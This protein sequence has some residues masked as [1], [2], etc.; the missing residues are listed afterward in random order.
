[1]ASRNEFVTLIALLASIGV[2]A[3]AQEPL[4]YARDIEPIMVRE[5]A[6]CHGAEKPKAELDLSP[7]HG[8]TA[9]TGKKSIQ[10]DMPL[11]SPGDPA[12]S[13]L[14]LKLSHTATK[15]KGMPRTLFGDKKLP[16][17]LL[18]LVQRWIVEGAKP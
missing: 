4:S 5:C 14:W 3:L 9:L 16:K 15:G 1:M 7:G 18:D 2:L 13:Y 12:G 6:D 17:E 10:V 11:V 8:L